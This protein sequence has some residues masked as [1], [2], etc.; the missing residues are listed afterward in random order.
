M[1]SLG[2]GGKLW[3]A[4]V[5]AGIS[6]G[7]QSLLARGI[8]ARALSGFLLLQIEGL[9]RAAGGRL[10]HQFP[11]AEED[12]ASV[13]GSGMGGGGMSDNCVQGRLQPGVLD[14]QRPRDDFYCTQSL[15]YRFRGVISL[16]KAHGRTSRMLTAQPGPVD[17]HRC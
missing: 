10:R 3:P 17:A 11:A 5:V 2:F 12:K 14:V 9:R 1:A 4:T 8:Y 16:I 6:D 7:Y 13:A 15:R